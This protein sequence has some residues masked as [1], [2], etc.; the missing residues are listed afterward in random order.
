[1]DSLISTGRLDIR[2]LE[3]TDAE[4]VFAYRSDPV[5]SRYQ[6]W[7]PAS[8][9]EVR[10]FISGLADLKVGTPGRWYQ[11]GIVLRESNELVGDL[12]VRTP[13]DEPRQA[14]VGITLASA[15]QGLGIA[16]EALSAVLVYLFDELGV[17]RVFASVDPRNKA[18]IALLER[19][20]MRREAHLSESLWFKGAWVDD[21]IYALLAREKGSL[22]RSGG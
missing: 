20:G 3:E 13:G 10:D 19:V 16:T 21:V 22:K 2:P 7:V 5:V 1:M 8:A 11:L 6:G 12:G 14:E 4:A 15:H 18:S 9:K 17:H